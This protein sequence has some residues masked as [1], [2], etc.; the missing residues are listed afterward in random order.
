MT[1]SASGFV[2]HV[3]CVAGG[4]RRT[5]ISPN[6]IAGNNTEPRAWAAR[7]RFEKYCLNTLINCNVAEDNTQ[8]RARAAHTRLSKYY[9]ANNNGT[10]LFH[11]HPRSQYH[12][13][14]KRFHD[15]GRSR[16]T[17]VNTHET[18]YSIIKS[19]KSTKIS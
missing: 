9:L 14:A 18:K 7:T 19:D 13:A 12:D 4:A 16:T 10:S 15:N 6:S 1:E 3:E 5:A 2:I 17:S 11:M 8:P